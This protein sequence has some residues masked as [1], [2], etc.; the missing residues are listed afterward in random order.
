M[1]TLF[2]KKDVTP[3]SRRQSYYEV[4]EHNGHKFAINMVMDGSSCL[5]FN[6][7]CCI[8]IMNAEGYFKNLVDN[9]NLAFK[10]NKDV[11]Y[12]SNI[13]VKEAEFSKAAKQFKDYVKAIY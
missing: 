3:T 4:F 12:S 13:S 2:L 8:A 1:K 6:S 9:Q 5:G 11:V 7:D 10:F